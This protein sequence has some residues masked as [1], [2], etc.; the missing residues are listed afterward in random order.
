MIEALVRDLLTGSPRRRAAAS[1]TLRIIN[2]ATV[3]E[4]LIAAAETG[5]GSREWVVA[6]LGRLPATIVKERLQG[7][8]LLGEIKPL[9]LLNEEENWLCSEERSMDVSFLL[10]QNL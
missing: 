9:L 7:E 6:T 3:L 4:S 2:T 8:S 5:S 1:E 10:K